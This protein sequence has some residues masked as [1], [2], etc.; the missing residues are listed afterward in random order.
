MAMTISIEP[1]VLPSVLMLVALVW[2]MR[3]CFALGTVKEGDP[4]C[5]LFSDSLPPLGKRA[6]NATELGHR[7]MQDTMKK[8][9][10]TLEQKRQAA[11]AWICKISA[12]RVQIDKS[13]DSLVEALKAEFPHNFGPA[14]EI[15]TRIRHLAKGQEDCY[16]MVDDICHRMYMMSMERLTLRRKI[17]RLDLQMESAR[18]AEILYPCFIPADALGRGPGAE[19]EG[20]RKD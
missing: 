8:Q 15:K 7:H 4:V 14:V 10:A 5:T 19:E 3:K 13:I 12:R 6:F 1:E 18:L 11:Y 16:G 20:V 9:I 2:V 17:D